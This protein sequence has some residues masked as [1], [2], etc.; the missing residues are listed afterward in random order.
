LTLSLIADPTAVQTALKERAGETETQFT[1]GAVELIAGG[2][3]LADDVERAIATFLIQFGRWK[4]SE[5]V[6]FDDGR[7]HRVNIVLTPEEPVPG[8]SLQVVGQL[9]SMYSAM[10][11]LATQSEAGEVLWL[12]HD[13]TPGMIGALIPADYFERR[14]RVLRLWKLIQQPSIGPESEG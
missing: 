13:V 7:L 2:E 5:N 14:D 9:S 6:V 8:Q 12:R 3:V 4:L 10:Y 11:M 1:I